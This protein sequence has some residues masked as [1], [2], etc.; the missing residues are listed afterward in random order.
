MSERISVTDVLDK[1][2][3]SQRKAKG[4]GHLRRGEILEAAESI[5]LEFGYDGAT[6][7]KIA[8][9]VGVS[10][11]ALYMH[12]R[13]K[14]EILVEICETTFA[15]VLALNTEI[16]AM[17]IEPVARVRR[18]LEAYMTFALTHP[19]AYQL[20]FCST[21]SAPDDARTEALRALGRRCYDLF[22]GAVGKIEEAG[23]LRFGD[24]DAAA[25]TSWAATHGVVTLLITQ[26]N[27]GWAPRETLLPL[28]L[29]SVFYG[30]V[31]G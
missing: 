4:S 23:L 28:M 12:F 1:A 10:S 30:L 7:R 3:R 26:P 31:R 16:A 25:Q 15:Q 18:M 5:F 17:Q 6:I 13:D 20:V 22:A 21:R 2:S 14:D 8:D 27:F 29:D 11:T 9:A 19:N 24:V